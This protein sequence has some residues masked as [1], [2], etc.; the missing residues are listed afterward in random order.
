ME[1]VMKRVAFTNNLEYDVDVR[2]LLQAKKPKQISDYLTEYKNK[3]QIAVV[4]CNDQWTLY[5]TD[6]RDFGIPCHFDR[7][8]K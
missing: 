4:F 1:R 3:T 2:L 7:L 8:E 5:D 6:Q